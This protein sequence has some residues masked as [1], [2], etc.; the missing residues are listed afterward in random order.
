MGMIEINTDP[1][2]RQLLWF[3]PPFALFCGVLGGLMFW[4]FAAPGA[5]YVLWVLGAAL[6]IVYYLIPSLRKPLYLAWLYA[7]LP[8]GWAI[9]HLLLAIV[10]YLVVT[11]IGLLMRLCRYDPLNRRFDRSASTY[12]VPRKPDDDDTS[13]FRQF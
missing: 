8:I 11:P 2:R 7:A 6:L 4:R 13:Y 5:A 1:S 3:G 9:S 10:Y 12:W